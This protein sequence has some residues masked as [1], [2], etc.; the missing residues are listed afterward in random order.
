MIILFCN[1][2]LNEKRVD[3]DYEKEYLTAKKL[4]F[5]VALI[6]L[7]ELLSGSVDKAT[8]RVEIKSTL[9]TAFIEGG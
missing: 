9:E 8:I 5:S 4:G 7:E 3:V 1:D 6:S 2:P